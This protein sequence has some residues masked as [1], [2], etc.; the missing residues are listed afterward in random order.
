MIHLAFPPLRVRTAT[1]SP[2]LRSRVS[3]NDANVV[4]L[5]DNHHIYRDST[6]FDYKITLYISDMRRND[7]EY[8]GLRI[9]E[10][11]TKPHKYQAVSKYRCPGEDPVVTVLEPRETSYEKAFC[12]FREKFE[13]CTG[14]AW[15]DRFDIFVKAE[16][17]SVA[18]DRTDRI[19]RMAAAEGRELSAEEK[20][21][22]LA[23]GKVFQYDLPMKGS[24]RGEVQ[25]D[26]T[27][28]AST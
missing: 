12:A 16:A 2:P 3:S 23:R 27:K 4:V 17:L 14:Y 6:G 9:F 20:A 13:E 28:E 15:D 5:P 25:L 19:F 26:L 11:H 10:T 7:N 24:P 22:A 21:D 1:P 8:M 18:Q